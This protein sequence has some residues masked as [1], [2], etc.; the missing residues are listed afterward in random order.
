MSTSGY[1]SRSRPVQSGVDGIV[2]GLSTSGYRLRLVVWGVV[3]EPAADGSGVSW[4]VR[5]CRLCLCRRQLPVD[6]G[7]SLASRLSGLWSA[8]L[9]LAVSTVPRMDQQDKKEENKKKQ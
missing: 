5:L 8:S 2:N 6:F 9:R 4:M 1:R 7:V 3:C